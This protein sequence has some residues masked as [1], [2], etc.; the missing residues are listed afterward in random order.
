MGISQKCEY[1][2]RALLE[3]AKRPGQSPMTSGEIAARQGIPSQFLANILNELKTAGLVVARRGVRG[4]YRLVCSPEL[5]SVGRVVRLV[6]GPLDP[7]LCTR[8]VHQ[9]DCSLKD[10]CSLPQLWQEAKDAVEAV[11]DRVTFAE[12]A[13]RDRLQDGR[14]PIE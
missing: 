7:V 3:L 9:L 2:V 11:Y 5:L 13:R 6:D 1:A 4:G 14:L 12:L 10:R 8:G